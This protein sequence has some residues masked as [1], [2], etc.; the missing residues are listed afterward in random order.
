MKRAH[1][2]L[3]GAVALLLTG[4][5]GGDAS[6]GAEAPETSAA[7]PF[8]RNGLP[9]APDAATADAYIA[10]LRDIDP[11]IVGDKDPKTVVNRGRDQCTAIAE[12][13][14]DEAKL[15]DLTNRRFTSPDH[16]EGFGD[17]KSKRI[18]AV[19]KEHICP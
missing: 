4:C 3:I 19:V 7:A 15:V 8:T 6:S 11:D 5:G 10:A 14:D 18:L 13:P 16:P 17:K 12:W 9:P 2:T 1:L